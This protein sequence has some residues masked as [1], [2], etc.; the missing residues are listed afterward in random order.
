MDERFVSV[1]VLERLTDTDITTIISNAV[2]RVSS[3]REPLSFDTP[4]PSSQASCGSSGP[5]SSQPEASASG[6]SDEHS[7]PTSKEVTFASFPQLKPRIVSS[8]V[9]LSTGDAR[10][11]ISL[12]DLVLNSPKDSQESTLLDSLRR[13]VATSY[14][15]TGDSHYDMISA[16]HKSVRGSQA[17]AAMYWLARMLTAG[18]DPLYIAR[19]MVVCAS[20]DI[21]LADNQALP[22]VSGRDFMF[23]SLNT[24]TGA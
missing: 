1:L 9:S 6:G 5:P 2:C 17:D 4:P 7:Q 22:L 8:I 16:L 14:D 19:R 11:A 10:T 21:G 3:T 23:R 20:E 12:L 18:E 15:R 13:S 24:L